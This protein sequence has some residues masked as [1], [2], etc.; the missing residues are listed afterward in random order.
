MR[1]TG[2]IRKVDEL[3]RVVVPIEIRRNFS[4]DIKDPVE[5]YTD[6]NCIIL[7]KYEPTCVFCGEARNVFKFK[8]KNICSKCAD[9]LQVYADSHWLLE[10]NNVL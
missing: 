8:E 2:V 4:I 3:G 6:D 5:I 1:A 9:K 7:K 10:R